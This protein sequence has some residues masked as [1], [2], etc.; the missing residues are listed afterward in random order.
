MRRARKLGFWN[1]ESA[2]GVVIHCFGLL[3][4]GIWRESERRE[5]ERV[6]RLR[7]EVEKGLQ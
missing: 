2:C 1:L 4:V 6:Q 3:V 5:K 7:G